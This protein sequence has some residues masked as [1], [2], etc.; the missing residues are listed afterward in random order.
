MT[1]FC[2]QH[3]LYGSN[4]HTRLPSVMYILTLYDK[5]CKCSDLCKCQGK[6][7]GEEG[8]GSGVKEESGEIGKGASITN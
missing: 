1:V 8:E 2:I 6:L 4:N 5:K 3:L 7:G